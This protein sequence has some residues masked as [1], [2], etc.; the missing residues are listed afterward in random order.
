MY[1]SRIRYPPNAN[2]TLN[3][4]CL[5]QNRCRKYAK[6][7]PTF[8]FLVMFCPLQDRMAV[9]KPGRVDGKACDVTVNEIQVEP[10]DSVEVELL[11]YATAS[12]FQMLT[13]LIAGCFLVCW[14]E[15]LL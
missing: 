14:L 6:P 10:C 8:P 4:L 13:S 1:Q 7:K 3:L 15:F 12:M 9:I 2:P 5:L 11:E